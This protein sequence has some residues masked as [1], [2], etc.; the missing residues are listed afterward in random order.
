MR[1]QAILR[2]VVGSASLCLG[3]WSGAAWAGGPAQGSVGMLVEPATGAPRSRTLDEALLEVER[4]APGFGGMYHDEKGR[5]VVRLVNATAAPAA[6]RAIAAVFG[7]DKLP[8]A[9]VVTEPATWT[10]SQLKSLQERL[11]PEVLALPGT[12]FTDVDEKSN[13]VAIGVERSEARATVERAIARLALARDAVDIIEMGPIRPAT[14]Q[15]GWTPVGGGL[16]IETPGKYCTLGFPALQGGTLGFVT[17]SHC[18]TVQGG[19]E[20]TPAYQAVAPW[21]VGTET[22]DPGYAT[23]GSCP[24]GRVCRSSDSAF[25]RADAAIGTYVVQTPGAFNLNISAWWDVTGKVLYPSQGQVVFKTGRTTGTTN[26]TIEWACA[27]V[28]S[29]GTPQTYYC[30]YIATSPTQNGAGGDSGSPVYF[31]TGNGVTLTGLMWGAGSSPWNFGFSPLGGVQAELGV[32]PYCQGG[33]GC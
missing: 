32:V 22:T 11:T 23:G 1:K 3:G 16:Q 6:R 9:G 24:A 15:S 20:S 12:V 28:N 18:T 25:F 8:S 21:Q 14:V 27:T 13:R 33:V 2:V 30:N 26:G 7:E 5:L 4:E 29:G 10:F 17:N 19:V 31:L